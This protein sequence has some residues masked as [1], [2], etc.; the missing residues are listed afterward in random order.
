M[1]DKF[2]PLVGKEDV[3]S[4]LASSSM[5]T[6][7]S[8]VKGATASMETGMQKV[9]KTLAKDSDINVTKEVEMEKPHDAVK[10]ITKKKEIWRLG[11]LLE[12]TWTVYKGG[13]QPNVSASAENDMSAASHKTPAKR[14]VAKHQPLENTNL[15]SHFSSTRSGKLIKKEKN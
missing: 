1:A 5:E 13:T 6:E 4:K 3:S 15:E 10:T 14:N 12:D 2:Q 11:V 7:K 9:E 8:K